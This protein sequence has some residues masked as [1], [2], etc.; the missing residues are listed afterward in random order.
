MTKKE[1]QT[2]LY[3][4]V[5]SRLSAYG[6]T[7]KKSTRRYRRKTSFGKH[8]VH[9]TYVDHYDHFGVAVD[10]AVRFDAIEDLL[11]LI[12]TDSTKAE[13]ADTFTIGTELGNLS[14]GR[15]KEWPVKS[16][17]DVGQVANNVERAVLDI[18]F[19]YFERYDNLGSVYEML[20]SLKHRRYE[21]CH[22]VAAAFLLYGRD[23]ALRD[24]EEQ[25]AYL[26]SVDEA[27]E[28]EKLQKFVRLAIES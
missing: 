13:K 21:A 22:I 23:V 12:R 17:G 11:G 1:H 18:A 16:D 15:W 6:F 26:L 20:K 28:A 24:A 19:P 14:E 7:T 3:D 9:L 10:I 27:G 4:M 25:G 2:L 8:G 5:A